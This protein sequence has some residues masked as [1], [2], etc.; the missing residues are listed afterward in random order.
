MNPNTVANVSA[1][2]PGEVEEGHPFHRLFDL[3]ATH[4]WH[5]ILGN[6]AEVAHVR[7]DNAVAMVLAVITEGLASPS[8]AARDALPNN[9]PQRI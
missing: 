8:M 1:S 5:L 3:V 2:T 6:L 4:G 7:G 9:K